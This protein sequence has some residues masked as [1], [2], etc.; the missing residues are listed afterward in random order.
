MLTLE[1]KSVNVHLKADGPL[2]KARKVP[3]KQVREKHYIVAGIADYK[4]VRAAEPRPGGAWQ[5]VVQGSI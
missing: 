3:L 1:R 2:A 4:P 5:V